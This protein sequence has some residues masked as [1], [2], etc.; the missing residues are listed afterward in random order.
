MGQDYISNFCAPG[1][2][3]EETM[4]LVSMTALVRFAVSPLTSCSVFP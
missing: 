3:E 1:S 4:S 2:R